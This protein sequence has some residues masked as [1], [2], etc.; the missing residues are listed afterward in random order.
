MPGK[1][2][3]IVNILKQQGLGGIVTKIWSYL[4]YHSREKWRFIYFELDL[5]KKHFTLPPPGD[6]ITIRILQQDDIEKFKIDIYPYMTEKQEY[7][8]RFVENPDDYNCLFFIAENEGRIIH[9]FVVFVNVLDSPLMETPFNKQQ[10]RSGDAYLGN[11][12]TVPDARGHWIVPHVLQNI[13]S[14]LQSETQAR[15]AILLV[16]EDTPGAAAFFKRLGFAEIQT[17]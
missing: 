14:Y 11:A 5:S 17:G 16:H 3:K 15:R 10:L 12:F 2:Q 13:I 1:I 7:D 6:T 8:K 9:Y 4:K